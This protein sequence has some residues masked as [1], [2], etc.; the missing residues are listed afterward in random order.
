MKF[1][2]P[3][4]ISMFHCGRSRRLKETTTTQKGLAHQATNFPQQGPPLPN[5]LLQ[6]R[7]G[8]R[9]AASVS[10][11]S[12]GLSITRNSDWHFGQSQRDCALQ[13]RVASLRATLGSC[14]N[15]LSTPT[16]LWL[17]SGTHGHNPVGV[18]S[19]KA[20]NPGL[21]VPRN[22]GLCCGIPSGFAKLLT[23]DVG[24]DKPTER[25]R[26][27]GRAGETARAI[28]CSTPNASSFPKPER[29]KSKVEMLT[30][31]HHA[32]APRFVKVSAPSESFA[33]AG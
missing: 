12:F 16:G 23:R 31:L 10:L 17:R 21:L 14:A 15:C 9:A 13:P 6:R 18:G 24:N 11:S 8:R 1:S 4:L 25:G 20:T 22:P 19:P 5:P 27:T 33:P 30:T 3:L 2:N 32:F 26:I 7:K 28:P 29:C